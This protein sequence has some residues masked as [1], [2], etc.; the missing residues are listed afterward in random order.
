MMGYAAS[1]RRGSVG[2]CI[3]LDFLSVQRA[4]CL[5]P[6]DR[7]FPAGQNIRSNRLNPGW[8]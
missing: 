8:F 3:L 6:S 4:K 7:I 1:F 2:I 5:V